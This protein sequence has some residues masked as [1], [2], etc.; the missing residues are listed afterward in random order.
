MQRVGW[1]SPSLLL[2]AFKLSIYLSNE[3][4]YREFCIKE[5]PQGRVSFKFSPFPPTL[6]P[7]IL[8]TTPHTQPEQI[9]L[10]STDRV[11]R[12]TLLLKIKLSLI[13][14]LKLIPQ[15]DGGKDI[16]NYFNN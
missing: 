11:I 3:A 16:S 1:A 13:G 10:R 5:K 6:S 15:L 9:T 7:N 14:E 8:L 12:V 2:I 4:F